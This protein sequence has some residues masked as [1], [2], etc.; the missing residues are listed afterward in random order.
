MENANG[1]RKWCK[2][3]KMKETGKTL[4]K[5]D[6]ACTKTLKTHAE[7]VETAGKHDNDQRKP[8]KIHW[9]MLEN[10]VKVQENVI[11][12]RANGAKTIGK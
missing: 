4:G 12:T 11:T 2:N 6:Y 7:D 9:K 5:I 8:C 1:Q 10:A 3:R